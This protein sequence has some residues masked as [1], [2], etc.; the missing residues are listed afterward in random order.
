M[1][2]EDRKPYRVLS[3]NGRWSVVD[4]A[5][6]LAA[7]CGDERN[8]RHYETLLNEAHDRGYRAGY[9]AAKNA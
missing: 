9:K 2:D 8:A 1:S 5:G 6:R 4:G 7:A 3:K